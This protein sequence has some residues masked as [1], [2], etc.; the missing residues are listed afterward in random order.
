L[1]SLYL[2]NV[3]LIKQKSLFEIPSVFAPNLP[4]IQDNHRGVG[5]IIYLKYTSPGY[6][7]FY[8]LLKVVDE[9]VV[10]GKALL[11]VPISVYRYFSML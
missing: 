3:L 4:Q 9:D 11:D 10:L 7:L 6:L 8:D 2:L 5:Q 1:Y